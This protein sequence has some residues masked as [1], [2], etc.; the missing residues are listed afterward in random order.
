VIVFNYLSVEYWSSFS[1][2]WTSLPIILS[3]SAFSWVT[4]YSL[5]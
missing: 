1:N 3:N 5:A 4:K 2:T